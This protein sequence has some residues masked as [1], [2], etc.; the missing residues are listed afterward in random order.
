MSAIEKAAEMLRA[1][2]WTVVPPRPAAMPEPA[3][4]QVWVSSKPRVEP[5]TIVKIGPARGWG[6]RNCV[7]FTA[8]S[9]AP[10]APWGP[11][12]LN[13]E[14]WNAWVRKSGA[15]PA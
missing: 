6:D 4:G 15:V 10:N 7:H 2:G 11:R 12:R 14:G 3:V 8:P 5:R 1:A 9:D 13:T